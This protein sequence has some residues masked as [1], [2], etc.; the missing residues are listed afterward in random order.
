M[1]RKDQKLQRKSGRVK[2]ALRL[3]KVV[4]NIQQWGYDKGIIQAANPMAQW[5]KTQEEV[6]E[7]K[8]AIEKK[9]REATIDAIGD[10]IVTVLLQAK[11]QKIDV[12][13]SLESVY[14]IISKRKG[15]LVNGT[16]VKES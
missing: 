4:E 3:L 9:D 10:V 15:K 14:D 13:E 6:N 1:A 16:F 11:I 2:S 12:T 8:E 5:N 7:L